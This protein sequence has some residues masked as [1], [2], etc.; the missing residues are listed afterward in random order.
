[1]P[2]VKNILYAQYGEFLIYQNK[3]NTDKFPDYQ[4]ADK[5]AKQI[6]DLNIWLSKEDV[7][8]SE[9]DNSMKMRDLLFGLSI[10]DLRPVSEEMH[11]HFISGEGTPYSNQ[12][13]TNK[14]KEH[15]KTKAFRKGVKITISS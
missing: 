14:V 4:Y 3:D 8:R 15:S 1:M 5:T 11:E 6:C 13:L 10:G 7:N 2:L 12:V 9:K